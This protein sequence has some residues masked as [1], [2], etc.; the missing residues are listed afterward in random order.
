MSLSE[1][2]VLTLGGLGLWSQASAFGAQHAQAVKLGGLAVAAVGAWRIIEAMK[3]GS[4][5][6]NVADAALGTKPVITD[7][8]TTVGEPVTTTGTD[9]AAAPNV[10]GKRFII[11]VTGHLVSPVNGSTVNP[12]VYAS[13]YPVTV[14]L[15]NST[16][17]AITDTL[18]IDVREVYGIGGD[19]R[20][21][22]TSPPI[23]I[24]AGREF[25]QVLNVPIGGGRV[26]YSRAQAIAS[27][28]FGR[29]GLGVYGWEIKT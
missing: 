2:V 24:P 28:T 6:E 20:A 27:F 15:T 8:G 17:N 19:E 22:V 16:P 18:T 13:T 26:R 21:T 14:R 4:L 1:G 3:A 11:P 25:V 29:R 5:L 7:A 23:T 9:T 12:N 10:P